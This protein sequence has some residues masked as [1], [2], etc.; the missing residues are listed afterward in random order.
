MYMYIL[1]QIDPVGD[2][3]GRCLRYRSGIEM[4][5]FVYLLYIDR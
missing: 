1:Q 4:N 2:A 5:T 3:E